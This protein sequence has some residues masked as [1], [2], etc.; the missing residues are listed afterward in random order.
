M[1]EEL[2]KKQ[3]EV[4]HFIKSFI[5]KNDYSPSLTE[6]QKRF[7]YKSPKAVVDILSIIERKKY[8]K[9]GKKG[10]SR[11]IVILEEKDNQ[12][13]ESSKSSDTISLVLTGNGNSENPFSIFMDSKG[14]ISFDKKLIKNEGNLFLIRS[15]DNGFKKD[16]IQ[17]G[18]LVIV[19]QEFT[20]EDG[21]IVALIFLD[22]VIVRKYKVKADEFELL[23]T[24]G[25]F[26]K[27]PGKKGDPS[28]SLLGKVKGLFRNIN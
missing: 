22:K 10:Q 19:K 23:A 25:R 8:I 20:F 15:Q 4:Y 7:K 11:S 5:N 2:T 18:D 26:P 16:G 28:I 14:E 6:I 21:D 1:K 12:K 17:E 27:I 3:S 13:D 9:R 24:D